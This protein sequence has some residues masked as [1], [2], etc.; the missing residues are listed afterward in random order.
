MVVDV[1]LLRPVDLEMELAA[2]LDPALSQHFQASPENTLFCEILTRRTQHIR[3]FMRMRYINY[4]HFTYLFTYF[5]AVLLCVYFTGKK[6]R[7]VT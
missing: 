5:L 2:S 7:N 6:L 1:S 4:L 3:D